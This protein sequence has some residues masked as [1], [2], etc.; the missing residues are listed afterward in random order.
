MKKFSKLIAAFL[1]L[2]LTLAFAP[3]AFAAGV[4]AEAGDEATVVFSFDNI[5]GID[6]N[7]EFSNKSIVDSVSYSAVSDL[8]GDF[9]NDNM[10]FSD[11]AA[12]DMDVYVTLKIKASAKAGD[13]CVVTFNYETSDQNGDMSAW[14][15]ATATVTVKA[16]AATT[17]EPTPSTKP[18]TPTTP[19]T[20]IDY[21]ELDRQLNIAA[22][23]DQDDY[24][25]DSWAAFAKAWTN[26]KSARSS[27]NQAAVD[28]AAKA[29]DEAIQGLVR[30]DYSK[31]QAA[32]DSVKGVA[33]DN[34][35]LNDLI[36]RLVAAIKAGE[37]AL[38]SND[39][40]AVD[41]AAAELEAV[42]AEL[43]KALEDLATVEK[44]IEEVPV[45]VDPTGPFCN[46]NW[47]KILLV[48]LIISVVLNVAFIALIVVYVVKK[49][50][51][52]KDTTPLVSYDIA[53][54]ET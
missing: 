22:G 25:S 51:N 41:A 14:K 32:L 16:A 15:K 49:K 9:L 36:D 1:V 52:Q 44:V 26:G 48:L 37:A 43:K 23:L 31:L 35:K 38:N 8:K 42:V 53:D 30:M 20:P 24:T 5:Y 13:T 34:E 17:P 47:H 3:A 19:S 11:A 12:D 33:G 28:A 27:T 39:Q 54:D 2:V 21:T 50:K 4:E 29:L 46:I 45:E 7:F 6:G 10:I 18:T 40:A